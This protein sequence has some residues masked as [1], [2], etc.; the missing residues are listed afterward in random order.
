[1]FTR[2][3]GSGR[4]EG[5]G[6]LRRPRSGGERNAPPQGDASVPTP[7]SP[8]P[9][10]T[11]KCR[12]SLHSHPHIQMRP[13]IIA[14]HGITPVEFQISVDIACQPEQDFRTGW[15][16]QGIV[17]VVER[18]GASY[19]EEPGTAI[20]V[21]SVGQKLVARQRVVVVGVVD[22]E[23]AGTQRHAVERGCRVS[24]GIGIKVFDV[25]A[26]QLGLCP[27]P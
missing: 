4:D 10:P 15:K 1:M 18:A 24:V 5:W 6:R 21:D 11:S 13:I 27:N 25:F 7:P 2:R 9:A 14:K 8:T 22:L 17:P 23:I 16:V 20:V 3:G 19:A 12:P 26:G